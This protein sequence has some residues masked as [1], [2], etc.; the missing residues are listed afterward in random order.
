M[1][2]FISGRKHEKVLKIL[3]WV[4]EV[5]FNKFFLFINKNWLTKSNVSSLRFDSK[6]YTLHFYLTLFSTT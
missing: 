4:R 1:D 5:S 2:N 6:S 3:S